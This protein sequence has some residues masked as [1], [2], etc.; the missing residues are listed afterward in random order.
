M[1]HSGR[2]SS[3]SDS[4]PQDLKRERDE[5]LQSLGRGTRLTEE[6]LAEVEE[7]RRR[8]AVLENENARLRATIQA[9][10]AIRD[11]LDKIESLEVEKRELLS[12]FKQ[13]EADSSVV[14]SRIH[15]MESEFANLAN[16]FVASNQMH[17][18]LSPRTVTRRIK[19]VLAQLVGAERYGIYLVSHDGAELVPIASEGLPAAELAPQPLASSVAREAFDSGAAQVDEERDPSTGTAQHPAAVIPLAI[20]DRTVGVIVI[21]STLEQKRS[22][23]TIDFQLFKLLGQHAAAAL[24]SASYY[25]QA[26]RQLPGL[27]AFLDLSV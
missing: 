10:H 5:L 26:G 14:S 7:L 21:V 19:E 12:K 18:S 13:A 27:E 11:L 8:M 3:H 4:P 25:V 1:S 15:E 2:S 23:E 6:F 22:F 24:V 17:S 16:L 20:D 9:D